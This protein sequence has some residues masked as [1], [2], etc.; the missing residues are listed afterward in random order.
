[1]AELKFFDTNINDT[2]ISANMTINN[3]TIVAEGNGESERI[4]R[5]F[6]I[7]RINI[8]YA[9]QL[10]AATAQGATSETV[11]CMLIQDKQTNGVQFSATDLIDTDNMNSFNNLAN[12]KRFKILYKQEY[13]FKSGGAIPTGA[14]F[15]FSEDRK[16]LRMSKNVNI[17][18][19]YDNT[20]TTGVIATVR[21]NNIYWVTQS[22][23]GLAGGTGLARIR[24][25][26]H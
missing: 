25:T 22:I 17:S 6:N 14:A 13:D 23:S 1:M 3:L 2:V 9:M 11:R 7:Y 24:Y 10:P 26:D 15:A 21:S 4:G 20:L 5:K 8:L 16:Y 18:I 19:E 12:S